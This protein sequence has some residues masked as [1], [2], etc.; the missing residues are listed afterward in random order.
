MV[1]SG[2]SSNQLP[3][4][5][6]TQ[7]DVIIVASNDQPVSRFSLESL[8][9][10]L[11]LWTEDDSDYLS[12]DPYDR[13]HQDTRETSYSGGETAVLPSSSDPQT[14][15]SSGENSKK[16]AS[17]ST[18]TSFR[19]PPMPFS[20]PPKMK[21][22]EEVMSENSGTDT[23]SLRKLTTALAREAIF[24][25]KEMATM[26]L[27]GRYSTGKLD[28]AKMNYIKTLVHSRVPKMSN[29]EFEH[30]WKLCCGS[31][32]KSCQTLRFNVKKRSSF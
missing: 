4:E 24:G 9:D 29:V 23:A 3:G 27:S 10:D 28:R 26:S 7:D 6:P 25:R 22:V 31:L 17:P 1:T 13:W 16:Y 15:T 19:I 21:E 18:P 5:L 20:T 32:S 12:M 30:V 11:D 14:A 8:T 2:S